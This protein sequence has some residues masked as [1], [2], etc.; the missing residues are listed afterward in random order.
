MSSLKLSVG[1]VVY[2]LD[3]MI[4]SRVLQSLSEAG[5][6][7]ELILFIVN[8]SPDVDVLSKLTYFTQYPWLVDTKIINNPENTGYGA[9]NN[10]AIK[11]SHAK[12]HL[13]LNPDAF[14]D[15][16]ALKN[17]LN[18][19]EA[20]PEVGLLCPLVLNEDGSQQFV[21]RQNPTLFDMFLR[22]FAPGFLKKMFARRMN[23]FLLKNLD[24]SKEQDIA[25]PSGCCMLFRTSVLKQI[26][27]FDE[28]FFM[29][30]EDSDIGRRVHQVAKVKYLP[31][32]KVVH[33]WARDAHKS[34]R[35]KK[36]L[37]K[38]GLKYFWKW[39]GWF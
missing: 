1:V 13:V 17:A 29:Y 28:R 21:H 36:I 6:G 12:Y 34:W 3:F 22:S 2:D 9:G 19:M 18:Y 26:G 24:W 38:S 30:Y 5:F 16:E 31:S 20:H 32:F 37:I 27:G 39:G 11:E 23:N 14:L 25:S 35:M 7:I 8:N 33:L 15:R 10:L 4:F